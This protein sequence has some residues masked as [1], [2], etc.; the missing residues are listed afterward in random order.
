MTQFKILTVFTNINGTIKRVAWDFTRSWLVCHF[1]SVS[2]LMLFWFCFSNSFLHSSEQK[3]FVS[4]PE[5]ISLKFIPQQTEHVP[6]LV[7]I[8]FFP[9]PGT[10]WISTHPL[11]F[12]GQDHTSTIW[13]LFWWHYALLI[14]ILKL[15]INLRHRS[16]RPRPFSEP[17]N[18]FPHSLHLPFILFP[19]LG[20][21]NLF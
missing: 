14:K 1:F 11:T 5:R 12:M 9:F 6:H 18:S 13:T 19:H 20:F 8:E 15:D 16:Q 21:L 3:N 2:F 4:P 17:F 10:L 7:S